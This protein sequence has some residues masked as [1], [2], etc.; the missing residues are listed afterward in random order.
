MMINWLITISLIMKIDPVLSNDS[1]NSDCLTTFCF[2]MEILVFLLI[3][4]VVIIMLSLIF[5]QKYLRYRQRQNTKQNQTTENELIIPIQAC[6]IFQS[7]RWFAYSYC[8]SIFPDDPDCL[9]IDFDL[10]RLTLIGR[11]T[12]DFDEYQLIGSFSRTELTV[13]MIKISLS[14]TDHAYQK[15]NIDLVWNKS[16]QRFEGIWFVINTDDCKD[17]GVFILIKEQEN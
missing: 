6:T 15:I 17:N 13:H 10:D 12:D 8:S 2:V 4:L 5:Y 14:P 1:I 9:Q 7:G 11:N 3:L 16:K